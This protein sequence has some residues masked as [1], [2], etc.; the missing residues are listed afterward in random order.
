GAP[1]ESDLPRAA[2][3]STVPAP[4]GGY[5]SHLGARPVAMAALHLGAGRRT[6]DDPIDH[7]VGVVCRKKIGD[8]V[9]AGEALAE[10]H[11]R[12]DVSAFEARAAV[13][14]AYEITDARPPARSVIL[15]VIA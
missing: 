8:P 15:D 14:A 9:V 2:S 13:L 1:A 11:A 5:V 10:I 12:D 4:R 7:A 3:V 6:K